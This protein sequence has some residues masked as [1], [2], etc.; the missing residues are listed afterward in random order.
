MSEVWTPRL[1]TPPGFLASTVVS[2]P[3][4]GRGKFKPRY[5]PDFEQLWREYI[6]AISGLSSATAQAILGEIY[7]ATNYTGDVNIFFGLWTTQLTVTSTGSSGTESAYGSYA[8][9]S[10]TNNTTNFPAPSGSAPT[11]VANGGTAITWPTSTSGS[12]TIISGAATSASSAGTIRSFGDITSTVINSGDTPKINTSGF[13]QTL[14][15]S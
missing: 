14:A 1:W 9:V 10:I 13:T 7:G 3:R 11:S 12:S 6:S 2:I 4:F 8:R 15:S 5:L